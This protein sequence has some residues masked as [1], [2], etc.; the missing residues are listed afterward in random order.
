MHDDELI[1]VFCFH[2]I[3]SEFLIVKNTGTLWVAWWEEMTLTGVL[4]C[5]FL[6]F[7]I[8]I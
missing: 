5:L 3:K 1:V 2:G 6:K 8:V 4:C 7:E